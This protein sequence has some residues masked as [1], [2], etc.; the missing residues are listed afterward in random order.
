MSNSAVI[1]TDQDSSR[2]VIQFKMSRTFSLKTPTTAFQVLVAGVAA[3]LF[4]SGLLT[5]AMLKYPNKTPD[6]YFEK[7]I[8]DLERDRH[9]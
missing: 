7:V 2:V 3:S 6:W 9:A 8:Y 4:A 1:F 5:Q